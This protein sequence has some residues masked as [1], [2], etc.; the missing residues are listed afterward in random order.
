M[1]TAPVASVVFVVVTSVVALGAEKPQA[2][3]TSSFVGST[4]TSE[5][6]LEG[7][8]TMPLD[9]AIYAKDR[10]EAKVARFTGMSSGLTVLEL[11]SMASQRAHLTTGTGHGGFA[12]EGWVD[13]TAIPLFAAGNLPVVAGHVWIQGGQRVEFEGRQQNQVRV[14]KAVSSPFA[15]SFLAVTSC[16]NLSVAPVAPVPPDIARWARGY[17]F[18]HSELPLSSEPKGEPSFKL[19]RSSVTA[20]VFLYGTDKKDDWVRVRYYGAIGIDAW[21]KSGDVRLLPKGERVDEY[22][23]ASQT[24]TGRLRIVESGRV[25]SVTELVQVRS[26]PAPDAPVVGVIEPATETLILDVAAGWASVLPKTLN[27]AP[28]AERQFWVEARKVGIQAKNTPPSGS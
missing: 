14:Q 8:T 18:E 2:A 27:V 9:V 15:Q 22:V 6:R 12:I 4:G 21:V 10:G 20:S 13:V 26:R 19:V 25:V 23:P 28:P 17:A 24:E 3:A 7:S 16:S 5:C 11:P 1:R